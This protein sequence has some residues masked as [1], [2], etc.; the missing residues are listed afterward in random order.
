MAYMVESLQKLLKDVFEETENNKQ[1]KSDLVKMGMIQ[2]GKIKKFLNRL[3]ITGFYSVFV[4]SVFT[5]IVTFFGGVIWPVYIC[6]EQLWDFVRIV[7]LW[8]LPGHASV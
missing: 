2:S 8:F 5:K 1:T 7:R 4:S 3:K 6:Y